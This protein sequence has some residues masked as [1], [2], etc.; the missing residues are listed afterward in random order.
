MAQNVDVWEAKVW[1]WPLQQND[2]VVKLI[3]T[4]EKF[5]VGFQ[6]PYFTPKEI[7]VSKFLQLSNCELVVKNTWLTKRVDFHCST[8]LKIFQYYS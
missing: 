4:N 3:N 8:V 1:D 7:E 5:E 6:V 2:G